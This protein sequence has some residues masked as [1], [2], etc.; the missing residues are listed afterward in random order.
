[1]VEAVA[2]PPPLPPDAPLRP[3]P[4]APPG[5]P[6]VPFSLSF[7]ARLTRPSPTVTAKLNAVQWRRRVVRRF[8]VMATLSICIASP[9]QQD[10]FGLLG[11]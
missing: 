8:G 10:N 5:F 9:N 11:I 7:A 4:P 3:V 1:V 2:P 6:G